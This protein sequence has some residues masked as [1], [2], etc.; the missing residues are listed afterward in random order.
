MVDVLGLV[1]AHCSEEFV[2]DRQAIRLRPLHGS[3][4]G[5]E[6]IKDQQVGDKMV[7]LNK[8]PLLIP[9]VLRN[10][11]VAAERDPLHKPVRALL[12]VAVWI[13]WRSSMSAGYN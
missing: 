13:M 7:V 11:V 6:V 2:R 4:Q 8:F 10:H 9:D 12:V 5:G 3:G 1:R